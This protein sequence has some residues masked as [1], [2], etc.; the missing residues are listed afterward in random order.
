MKQSK[1][2]LFL[3]FTI[4]AISAYANENVLGS[5]QLVA[6]N[7]WIY[8]GIDILFSATGKVSPISC[9]PISI[10][11]LQMSFEQIDFEKLPE[12]ARKLYNDVKDYL[13]YKK[14]L[15]SISGVKVDV[16]PKINAQFLAK[17]NEDLDWNF[18]TDYTA[19]NG[20]GPAS[21][22]NGEDSVKKFAEANLK[23]DF[24]NTFFIETTPFFGTNFWIS[25]TGIAGNSNLIANV[26][27][28]AERF[29]FLEPI[30]AYGSVGKSF[31]NWGVNFNVLKEGLQIG[32]THTGSVIYNST[33]QTEFCA[34]LNLYSPRFSY[35][36]DVAQIEYDKY[37][38]LHYA[39]A[40]VFNWL[41]FGILEGTLINH[42]FELRYLNPL[43][44]MHSFGSWTEYKTEDEDKYYGEAHV[45]AYVAFNFDINPCRYLRIYGLYAQNEIQTKLELGSDYGRSIPDGSAYQLG[46]DFTYPSKNGFWIASLEG[47][48]VY[49]FCYMKTGEE[50][51]LVY[52]RYDMQHNVSLP[53]YSWIGTPFGPD[54]IAAQ[55]RFGFTTFSKGSLVLEYLFVAHG[56]NSF[57]LFSQ[58][59]DKEGNEYY[60][61]Y[62]SA[63]YSQGVYSGEEAAKVARSHALSGTVS[64]T[65]AITLRQNYDFNDRFSLDSRITYKAV[66]NNKNRAGEIARGLEFSIAFSEKI[67]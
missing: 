13:Q 38:Y 28:N 1:R 37:L 3:V 15:I 14:G 41:R 7:S 11:E 64:F 12:N 16:V 48:Y 47:V 66:Y 55:A 31:G 26:P 25:E 39:Q 32:K 30:W 43:M 24:G 34:Q 44:I 53:I 49:P 45:C 21:N 42:G 10:A 65:N 51:S 2:F 62:P 22:A 6:A 18:A 36:L 40:T 46:V 61:Y 5:Q 23:L 63:K 35:N 4:F 33:F 9:A 59:L 19:H 17:T 52:K 20:Y 54:S 56:E 60:S 29:E 67:L 50:W 8:D 58:K 27:Y 57:G